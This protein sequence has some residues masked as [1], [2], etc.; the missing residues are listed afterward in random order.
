MDE[1]KFIEVQNVWILSLFLYAY[2]GSWPKNRTS[3][4]VTKWYDTH[5]WI[6]PVTPEFGFLMKGASIRHVSLTETRNIDQ[7]CVFRSIFAL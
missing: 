7:K 3:R 2:T 6:V 4:P 1:T 5:K